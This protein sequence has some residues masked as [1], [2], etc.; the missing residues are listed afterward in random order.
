MLEYL[1]DDRLLTSCVENQ[2]SRIPH[3]QCGICREWVEYQIDRDR[4]YFNSN[5]GCT[6]IYNPPAPRS[7][8]ELADW[9]NMQT[10]ANKRQIARVCGIEL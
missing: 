5:C 7:W 4:L 8:Q 1:T 2:I 10:D 9:I 6:S 3:H